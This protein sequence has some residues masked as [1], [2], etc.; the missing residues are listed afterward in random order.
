MADPRK[1][2]RGIHLDFT[3]TANLHGRLADDTNGA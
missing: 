1:R 2:V 3:G